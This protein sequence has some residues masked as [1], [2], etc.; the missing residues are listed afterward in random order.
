MILIWNSKESKE[1]LKDSKIDDDAKTRNQAKQ[2]E[3]ITQ[4]KPK[5]SK[6]T[7]MLATAKVSDFRENQ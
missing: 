3:K 2:I 4:K 7:T 5:L 1:I 6:N